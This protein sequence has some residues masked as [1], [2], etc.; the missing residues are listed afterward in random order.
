MQQLRQTL[1]TKLTEILEQAERAIEG[2]PEGLVRSR[3]QHI[4]GLT[5]QLKFTVQEQLPEP[6]LQA[7]DSANA[8][9]TR[10]G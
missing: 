1:L 6:P 7:D 4:R 9:T 3:V 10:P 5:K 8:G 2:L